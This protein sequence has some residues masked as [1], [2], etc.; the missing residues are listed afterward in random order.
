MAP[1]IYPWNKTTRRI[2]SFSL[3]I[4]PLLEIKTDPETDE[5]FTLHSFSLR[6]TFNLFLD[7]MLSRCC[8]KPIKTQCKLRDPHNADMTNT[9]M[10]GIDV[11][12]HKSNDS[13]ICPVSAWFQEAIEISC[14]LWQCIATAK[15]QWEHRLTITD[16]T[17]GC[18]Q[19]VWFYT[20]MSGA[21]KCL[22]C[23]SLYY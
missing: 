22:P 15:N 16:E 20:E 10:K 5:T 12:N 11:E 17:S 2:K 23:F 4:F 3:N 19:I 1:S 6:S 9:N 18:L 7:Q 14:E 21:T 8:I 13:H